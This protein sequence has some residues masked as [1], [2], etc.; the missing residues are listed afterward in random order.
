VV[1]VPA[2]ARAQLLCRPGELAVAAHQR[3]AFYP[4]W[5]GLLADHPRVGDQPL[6]TLNSGRRAG[7]QLKVVAHQRLDRI[8][9]HDRSGWCQPRHPRR[10]IGRQPVDVVLGGVQ[11]H[12]TAVH[13][14][15]HRDLHPEPA[16]GLFAEFGDLAG[17]L[18]PGHHRAPYVVLMRAGVPEHH[19]QPVALGGHQRNANGLG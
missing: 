10:Q 9:D 7:F 17:D 14:Y 13:P 15:P 4:G 8:R 16:L 5:R 2:C 18:E 6:H 3:A 12:Q 19:E 11:I 1:N